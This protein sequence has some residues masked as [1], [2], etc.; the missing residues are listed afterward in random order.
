MKVNPGRRRPILQTHPTTNPR[1]TLDNFRTTNSDVMKLCAELFRHYRN[2]FVWYYFADVITFPVTSSILWKYVQFIWKYSV[3]FESDLKL[4]FCL[5]WAIF[6][7]YVRQYLDVTHTRQVYKN[8][9][10]SRDISPGNPDNMRVLQKSRKSES[11]RLI[12]CENVPI[13]KVRCWPNFMS[14]ALLLQKLCL[15]RLFALLLLEK[16]T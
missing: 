1:P 10:K 5:F 4:L 15:F 7:Q 12:I 11:R 6:L 8:L 13:H 16:P 14:I 2:T 3:S 9:W